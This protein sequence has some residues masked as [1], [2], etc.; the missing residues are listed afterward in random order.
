M[1]LPSGSKAVS[2]KWSDGASRKTESRLTARMVKMVKF[3]FDKFPPMGC[4]P[5]SLI[6]DARFNTYEAT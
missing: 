5:D 2:W 3:F 6:W 4:A 1:L